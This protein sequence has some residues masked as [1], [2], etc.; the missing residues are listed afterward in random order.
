MAVEPVDLSAVPDETIFP[1][2]ASKTVEFHSELFRAMI[3]WTAAPS[4]AFQIVQR[5]RSGWVNWGTN[6]ENECPEL[7]VGVEIKTA[8][9]MFKDSWR[10]V[11]D[12]LATPPNVTDRPGS[13]AHAPD[14][15]P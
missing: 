3:W 15:T 13:A 1:G 4:G 5:R 10:D 7:P 11:A 8:Y 14:G 2:P 12:Q 9:G 6:G